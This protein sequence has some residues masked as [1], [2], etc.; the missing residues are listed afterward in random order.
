MMAT[1]KSRFRTTTAAVVDFISAFHGEGGRA[2]ISHEEVEPLIRLGQDCG[3]H[4]ASLPRLLLVGEFKAGKSTLL[5]AILGADHAA[6]DLLEMTSWIARYWPASNA[7]CRIVHRDGSHRTMIPAEF[8]RA[9]QNRAWDAAYLGSIE[10]VDVGIADDTLR[11]VLIDA[12]GMGSVTR[13]NEAVLLSSLQDADMVLWT[14]DVDNVG[15][16]REM[17]LARKLVET[18]IPLLCVLTK[19]D[20]LDDPDEAEEI[21][22]YLADETGIAASIV[23]PVSARDAFDHIRF[24][25]QPADAS[26]VPSLMQHLQRHATT[27]NADLRAAAEQAHDGL[28]REH[29]VQ[30][31]DRILDE[32]RHL[33]VSV[34]RFAEIIGTVRAAVQNELEIS[35]SRFVRETMFAVERGTLEQK[36]AAQMKKNKGVLSEE[37]VNGVFRS[38][39]GEDYFEE[40]WRRTSELV[41][42]E[43]SG[44]WAAH[45]AEMETDLVA[46]LAE[47]RARADADLGQIVHPDDLQAIV[48][49]SVRDTF[50]TSMTT[51]FGI[52]AAATAYAA[53]LGPAAAAVTF[54]SAATGIGLPIA[55]IGAGVSLVYAGIRKKQLEHRAI[56]QAADVLDMYIDHFDR[57]ILAK[58]FY[59]ELSKLNER[60]ECAVVADFRAA[61]CQGLPE[62]DIDGMLRTAETLRADLET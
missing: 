9:C 51:S 30:L 8:R 34:D 1:A 12:P 42:E 31:L 27:R 40:F 59:P 58:H 17:S 50:Q 19:C 24:G 44:R 13:A 26:G 39:L 46:L 45:L 33:R 7:F 29:A 15:G 35:I 41:S 4:D 43:V 54:G 28:M 25:G 37:A 61:A 6:T 14:V 21:R 55:A 62:Q 56:E 57:E 20:L 23:F 18:G 32:L 49:H 47:F 48:D 53:W 3:F 60:V 16:S 5:N 52:A 10:H 11:Y 38:H 2:L 36:L 22:E